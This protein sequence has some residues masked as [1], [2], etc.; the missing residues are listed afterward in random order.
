MT[1][2]ILVL[3]AVSLFAGCRPRSGE[4]ASV[5]SSGTPAGMQVGQ[6]VGTRP[7]GVGAGTP[8]TPAPGHAL[9]AFALGCFWGSEN[10]FRHVPGVI[11]TAVG[12]AGGH[13]DHPTY[14]DVCGHTTGHAET[15][16]VEFDP[17]QVSYTKLLDVFFDT[18]DPTT[19]NRQ[20]PDV[21][22][23]Y[24]S[25]IFFFSDTQRVEAEKASSEEA[26]RLGKP[27]TTQLSAM[28]KFWIAEDYHQQY[29]EK[30]GRESCPLPRARTAKVE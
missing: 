21:G 25:A 23:Q 2:Q 6:R 22:D 9:A 3:V 14:E 4:A 5:A 29:D 13:T 24:R 15:V 19:L 8:L 16:L 28:P 20:G 18:H 26:R 12:Y 11:A 10:T 7:G 1:K 30:T 17:K 27:V